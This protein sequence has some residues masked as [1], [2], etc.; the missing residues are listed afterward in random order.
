ML[1]LDPVPR[2]SPPAKLKSKLQDISLEGPDP[3]RCDTPTTPPNVL[4]SR[5]QTEVEATTRGRV[6]F[7]RRTTPRYWSFAIVFTFIAQCIAA[8]GTAEKPPKK[9]PPKKRAVGKPKAAVAA[10]SK[11]KAKE[12]EDEAEEDRN[13]ASD[14][15]G[16]A[17]GEDGE[18]ELEEDAGAASK[19]YF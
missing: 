17:D 4:T 13:T 16:A 3:L 11:I 5:E 18:S 14:D 9:A 2:S 8:P 12:Q 15:E 19:R 1:S 6:R 7:R 10:T